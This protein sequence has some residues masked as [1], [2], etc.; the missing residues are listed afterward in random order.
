MAKYSN[1]REDN[2]PLTPSSIKVLEGRYL[3]KDASGKPIETGE[4]LFRRVSQ[5]V[6]KAD[7]NYNQNADLDKTANEFYSM[8]SNLEF[9]PNSPTLMN[10]GRD[11]QQLSGCFVLPIED[12]IESIFGSAKEGAMVHKS[13]GGT[14][15]SFS[16]L[17]PKSDVVG[18]TSGVSSGPVSFMYAHNTYTDVVKQGGTRRGANMGMLRVDH[19]DIIEFIDEKSK[20]NMKNKKISESFAESKYIRETLEKKLVEEYQLNNFNISVAI[21]DKFMEAYERDQEY[22][23]ISPKAKKVVGKMKAREVLRKIAEN[24]WKSGEP[25]VVFIDQINKYNPTPEIGEIEST[26]PCGEQPLLP[27]ESCNL[28]SINLSKFVNEDKKINYTHLGETVEKS[29]HFLDNVIDMNKYPLQEIEKMTKANRKIGLG[30]MGFA[31]MLI[32]LNIPYNSREAIKVAEDIMSFIQN[33]SKE[34]SKKLAEERNSFPNIDKSNY[35]GSFMRN[36]ATTTIAPTGTIGVIAG[37]SQGIEPYYAAVHKRITPQFEL[38]EPSQALEELLR[39]KGINA[40]ELE[41][42]FKEVLEKNNGS[43]QGFEKIPKDI[44]ELF[45]TAYDLTPQQHIEIQAAFQ[46]YTDNAVSKTVNLPEKATVED[47][48]NTYI[49]SY[50]SGCKGVTV[51]RDKSRETQVLTTNNGDKVS[52]KSLVGI[53]IEEE[54]SKSRPEKVGGDTYEQKTPF[55]GLFITINHDKETGEFYEAFLNIGKGGADVTAMAEGYGRLLSLLF[56]S[57]VP[58]EKIIK[59][60][61]NIGGKSQILDQKGSVT[62]LPDAIA[63]ALEKHLEQIKE[64]NGIKKKKE[65]KEYVKSGNFCPDCGSSLIKQ[66]GC[67]KCSNS[68]CNYTRC[69]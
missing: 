10:A 63:S 21:T 49:S 61:K 39:E 43:I 2:L 58:T 55:G 54:L 33:K 60:L 32:K 17:R 15:Y 38:Y 19:P 1:G 37:A 7:K 20:P 69:G 31:D 16:R 9:L 59:Q 22:E 40:K 36:A 64:E 57:K 56:K 6:A 46:K 25:G 53:I 5:N 66:E 44:R 28:G 30:V 29:V 3:K 47:I 68:D 23:L 52:K 14:G 12:S 41:N 11:L 50:R 4:E 48:L 27:Y 62:S 67:E 45:I 42:L 65:N 24:A 51:Y 34:A 26:N 8:M 13:G 18:S 35:K